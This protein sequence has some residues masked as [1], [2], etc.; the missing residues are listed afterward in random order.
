MLSKI[1]EVNLVLA[2]FLAAMLLSLVSAQAESADFSGQPS[3]QP[4]A[5]SV[6]QIQYS[7]DRESCADYSQLRKPLFGDLHVHTA[8][9]FDAVAGRINTMPEDA[10]DYAMGKPIASFPQNEQG[11][12]IGTAQLNRPLDFLSVTDHSEFLGERALCVNPD[13]SEYE[14]EFCTKYREIEFQGTLMLA[15]RLS[16]QYPDFGDR[17]DMLC[18]AD[19]SRCLEAAKGPW[20]RI[21]DAAEAAYDRSENCTFTS[22]VGY[23]YSGSPGQSNY[24][25]NV[26]FRNAKVPE[27]PISFFEAPLDSMLWAQLDKHCS[28][29][30]NCD[31]ITIPHNTNLSNGKLLTPYVGLE[32]TEENKINYAKTRLKRE[33]IMEIFQHKGASECINGLSSVLGAVDELC[34]IE[35]VRVMGK[36][37]SAKHFHLEG[38]DIVMG[39]PYQEVTDECEDGEFGRQGMMGGGCVSRNDFVR[40]ALITGLEEQQKIGYNPVKI[41][42]IASTDGHYG[43]PG[44]VAEDAWRGAV[45]GEMTPEQRLKPGHLPSGIKGNPGGLAGV[46][47]VENSRDAIFD[48]MLRR[49]TFGTS[50]PRIVPRF[51][52]G[53]E[54]DSNS[55]DRPD[56][57]DHGYSKGVPMGGDLPQS[58][59]QN[60]KPKFLLAAQRD[61][62]GGETPLQKLQI[63]KGWVDADGKRR[64]EVHTVAGSSNN[65]A[66]VDVL[67]GERYGEGH[68][69]LCAV[70]VDEDFDPSIPAY[71]YLRAVENPS[72]RW[73][74]LDC[75]KLDK[76]ARPA[77][78]EEPSRQVIQEMAWSSPIWYTPE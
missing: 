39:E 71:Y 53:W 70:F 33:P 75:L 20:Q 5:P 25:R 11:E 27:L 50:G 42:I 15:S 51:F 49:E 17:V 73:S 8:L 64:Y 37:T 61:S 52:A 77:V 32:Q 60:Q 56:M 59:A 35:Q 45:S 13:S 2:L 36:T 38:A 62:G 21:Q 74:L 41:G 18:G 3:E 46:W 78:C 24:H 30:D 34:E 16:A 72:P 1:H 29:E 54:L 58:S 9:S 48:A 67:T 7:E 19:D 23:E 12:A 6:G 28:E 76:E 47:A 44:D 63:V 68:N 31:Y 26:I 57:V 14:G 43:T 69:S 55:C 40:S 4:A 22:F 10:F 65:N 66:G